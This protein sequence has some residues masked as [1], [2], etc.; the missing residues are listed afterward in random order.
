MSPQFD[1]RTLQG[2]GSSGQGGSAGPGSGH[3][4]AHHATGLDN[5]PITAPP[6]Q[7][8]PLSHHPGPVPALDHRQFPAPAYDHGPFVP[9]HQGASQANPPLAAYNHLPTNPSAAYDFNPQQA[10]LAASDANF[11]FVDPAGIHDA[12]ARQQ[13]PPP[14]QQPTY[15]FDIPW[16][17]PPSDSSV[18]F[19]APISP[20]PATAGAGKQWFE[21]DDDD[22]DPSLVG[23][24]GSQTGLG[25]DDSSRSSASQ[26]RRVK[27]PVREYAGL[28]DQTSIQAGP[29]RNAPPSPVV[30]PSSSTTARPSKL[31]SASRTSK[32]THH[33]PAETPEERRSRA[34]HNLVEK[35][36]RN[37][38]NAQ[39]EN[40]L[41]VLPDHV[42]SGGPG[43]EDDS[44]GP[45]PDT[46]DRRVS[47]AEVLEMARRHIKSLE[48]NN[49]ALA[50]ERDE[51]AEQVEM[52]RNAKQSQSPGGAKG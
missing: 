52:M 50:R 4:T 25:L 11:N 12:G 6:R 3:G 17:G 33:K 10:H 19:G 8:T 2:A 40:L 39:F 38:L 42:R 49:S 7:I 35:Q 1:L 36:Y 13:Q 22:D 47:K 28:G 21:A 24:E 41:N 48:R 31:R 43:E 18:S 30:G 45:M 51:L 20:V 29:S 44:E 27:K 34:S 46:T 5:R 16:T 9:W 15:N 14:Q 32:N 23:D 37:R 26:S